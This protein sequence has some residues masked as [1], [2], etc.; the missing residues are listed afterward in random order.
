MWNFGIGV[1]YQFGTTCRVSNFFLQKS[2]HPNHHPPQPQLSRDCPNS[3]FLSWPQSSVPKGTQGQGSCLMTSKLGPVCVGRGFFL[4]LL[5]YFV[6]VSNWALSRIDVKLS[7]F[8]ESVA[9]LGQC[10]HLFYGIW[11][12]YYFHIQLRTSFLEVFNK[13]LTL[14]C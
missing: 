13:G 4:N 14:P 6:G 5:W 1:L 10:F 12:E 9:L 2:L 8:Q 11:I 7:A 3:N